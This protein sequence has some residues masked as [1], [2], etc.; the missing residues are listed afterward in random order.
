MRLVK[1]FIILALMSDAS[2]A[3]NQRGM[4]NYQ[5]IMAGK[6]NVDQLNPDEVQEVLE[7]H[8][9]LDS[10]KDTGKRGVGACAGA[11]ESNLDGTFN[12]WD[13][14]TIF[15]LTNGQIWQQSSYAY[16]YHYAYRPQVIIYPSNGGCKMKV[17]GVSGTIFVQLLK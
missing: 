10:K 11:I 1:I 15:K 14:E 16:T 17:D 4:R 5:E 9:S 7:V 13:G 8:Q 12:G 2:Y 6:K 3:D